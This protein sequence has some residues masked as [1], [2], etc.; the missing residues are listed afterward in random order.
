MEVTDEVAECVYKV[1]DWL[2]QHKGAGGHGEVHY[3]EVL[4]YTVIFVS[5]NCDEKLTDV[6]KFCRK[7]I[8]I[9]DYCYECILKSKPN[10]KNTVIL[11]GCSMEIMFK[12]FVGPAVGN[13]TNFFDYFTERI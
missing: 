9:F 5:E 11:E 6:D 10:V 2:D 13:I 3:D 1:R 7:I 4:S 12:N 8:E